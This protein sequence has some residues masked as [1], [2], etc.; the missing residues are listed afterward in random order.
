MKRKLLLI[1]ALTL[2]VVTVVAGVVGCKASVTDLVDLLKPDTSTET[3]VTADVTESLAGGKFGSY[4]ISNCRSY[5][6]TFGEGSNEEYRI[7][8][9]KDDGSV[10]STTIGNTTIDTVSLM[11]FG[12]GYSVYKLFDGTQ[13]AYQPYK[14]Y[15]G[16]GTLLL[17]ASQET[18]IVYNTIDDTTFIYNTVEGDLYYGNKDYGFEAYKVN[19]VVVNINDEGCEFASLV[20]STTVTEV[21]DYYYEYVEDVYGDSVGFIIYDKAFVMVKEV[22][23]DFAKYSLFNYFYTA[24]G[25]IIVQGRIALPKDA[26]DYDI[27]ENGTKYDFETMAYT[28]EYGEWWAE[29]SLDEYEIQ[30]V[31]AIDEDSSY[32]NCENLVWYYPIVDQHVNQSKA[33]L[34]TMGNDLGIDIL[35]MQEEDMEVAGAYMMGDYIYVA[36]EDITQNF[37]YYKVYNQDGEYLKTINDALTTDLAGDYYATQKYVYSYVDIS[38]SKEIPAEYTFASNG[39]FTKVVGTDTRY[40]YF[41]PSTQDFAEITAEGGKTISSVS[42]SYYQYITIRYTDGTMKIVDYAGNVL[43]Q[44]GTYQNNGN[45][46]SKINTDGTITT[47]TAIFRVVTD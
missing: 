24:D 28:Q 7:V 42:G 27:Y 5:I 16:Y 35:I 11:S 46:Y 31:A 36:F 38:F 12:R 10:V 2:V 41:N 26:S 13:D 23:F 33:L 6:M 18:D 47:A 22:R 30:D 39:I 20:Q 21:G 14:I 17:E 19:D 34:A 43:L 25:T 32:Q 37:Y 44:T 1:L 40:Y 45:V 15:D 9:I 8:A 4:S 3:I 29:T